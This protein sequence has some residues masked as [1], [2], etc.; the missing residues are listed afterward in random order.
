VTNAGH[1]VRDVCAVVSALSRSS[2]T[3]RNSKEAWQ[4]VA[5]TF[6]M[7]G[8]PLFDTADGWR[9]RTVRFNTH[10][11]ALM[12]KLCIPMHA[13]SVCLL[14][15]RFAQFCR[16]MCLYCEREHVMLWCGKVQNGALALT[17]LSNSVSAD[18][19]NWII[20]YAS[21]DTVD[22]FRTVPVP[23]L[24][25]YVEQML[26][27]MVDI[28][29][30]IA[31]IGVAKAIVKWLDSHPVKD[32]GAFADLFKRKAHEERVSLAMKAAGQ[33]KHVELAAFLF[34]VALD[35]A[36]PD[37]KWKKIAISDLIWKNF[38]IAFVTSRDASLNRVAL[39]KA[40]AAVSQPRR[41]AVLWYLNAALLS[42][43]D[44]EFMKYIYKEY[45]I[46][47]DEVRKLINGAID[48]VIMAH[49]MLADPEKKSF[50][51]WNL[52]YEW[53]TKKM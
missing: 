40:L 36:V 30:H 7:P 10:T 35:R 15:S 5:I 16:E 27:K 52:L 28:P 31:P 20:N 41:Q 51:T 21:S 49:T 39:W 6:D 24:R 43:H 11:T 48:G 37:E 42:P 23:Q 26:H 14:D 32:E 45:N 53:K 46:T 8:R 4:D 44:T 19:F 17:A 9:V 33:S 2:K 38:N 3:L 12:H 29:N 1:S 34:Q 22:G 47:G 18:E 25:V 13:Y 50:D